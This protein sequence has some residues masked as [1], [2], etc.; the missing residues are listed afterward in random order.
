MVVV[1]VGMRVRMGIREGGRRD[2]DRE[3]C[4]IDEGMLNLGGDLFYLAVFRK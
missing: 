1:V 2:M 4:L 3:G